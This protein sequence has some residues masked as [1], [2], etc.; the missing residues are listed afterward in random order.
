MT[1]SLCVWDGSY[2]SNGVIQPYVEKHVNKDSIGALN[3]EEDTSNAHKLK[4]GC[5]VIFTEWEKPDTVH[6][7]S[8]SSLHRCK[9]VHVQC[10]HLYK[11]QLI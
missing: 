5:Q 7:H 11:H 9:W 2:T 10:D 3:V 1:V 4:D 8:M 6:S